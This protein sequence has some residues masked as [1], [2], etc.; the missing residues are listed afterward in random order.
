[1]KYSTVLA[2]AILAGGIAQP[3]AAQDAE[4]DYFNGIYVGGSISGEFVN[5]STNEGLVF[6]TDQ[7]G[8]FDN[9]VSTTTGANAFSPGL[10]NGPPNAGPATPTCG[11]DDAEIGYSA[12]IGI[13][14]RLG[15]WGVAGVVLEGAKSNAIDYTTGFSTTP[16]SYTVS[17]E[18][19]YSV[20]LRGR[21]GISPGSGR[22][23]IYATGGVV[24]GKMDH[25][26]TTT[27]SANSFTEVND[28]DW[29]WGGQFGAGAELYITDNI[30]FNLEYLRTRY[31]SDD[32]YVAVG[33][34]TA[35]STNPFLLD[36]GGTN[37]RPSDSNLTIDSFRAGVNVR[38]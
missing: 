14:R 21:F 23:L 36:S 7:D 17:R 33:A 8:A 20:A 37:L 28:D 34:G 19:D 12:K 6:D 2:T 15:E 5:D 30:S 10:C 3:A 32:Y 24:Y 35:P 31:E 1:M 11:D 18:V 38:F 29:L 22:G 16:A 25:G 9:V 13:D 27:N 4:P 26:F